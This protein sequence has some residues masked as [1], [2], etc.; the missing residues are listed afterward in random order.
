MGTRR[1]PP[2]RLGTAQPPRSLHPRRPQTHARPRG[3]GHRGAHDGNTDRVGRYMDSHRQTTRGCVGVCTCGHAGADMGTRRAPL[4]GSHANTEHTWTPGQ[5][6]TRAHPLRLCTA[7]AVSLVSSSV[8]PRF[9]APS[10]VPG[11][12]PA[13]DPVPASHPTGQMTP[14]PPPAA[15]PVAQ[16]RATSG[17]STAPLGDPGRVKIN[18]PP[19]ARFRPPPFLP[20]HSGVRCVGA[21]LGQPPVPLPVL[22]PPDPLLPASVRSRAPPGLHWGR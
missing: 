6:H 3:R 5:Q 14:G 20:C 12:L 18:F 10:S 15:V 13:P 21:A 8:P 11:P 1:A 16:A 19:P 22:R 17:A 4:S 2:L 7:V 9:R